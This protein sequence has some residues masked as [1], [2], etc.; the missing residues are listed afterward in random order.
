MPKNNADMLRTRL[1]A[2][3]KAMPRD[4]RQRQSHLICQTLQSWFASRLPAPSIV[5]AFWPL[6]DEPDLR[7][8]L[9]ELNNRGITVV[10][11]VVVK[12]HTPLAFYPWTPQT[13]LTAGNFGV[14]EPPR[15]QA[16]T[17]DVL[18]VPT[19][20]FTCASDRLGYGG[21]YYDRTLAA[22]HARH[23][24]ITTIGIAWSEA[25]LDSGGREYRPQAHDIRL[26]AMLT[27]QGWISAEPVF[28]FSYPLK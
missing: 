6:E 18:L 5:A 7:P 13:P 21:G 24:P 26:D 20:G 16:C 19:L 8:L 27:G 15:T 3:R 14:M 28:S 9:I 10:L 12:R 11:P 23:L 2:E 4:L 17:P 22:L 25:Q 1:L